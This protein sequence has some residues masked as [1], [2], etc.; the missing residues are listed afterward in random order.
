MKILYPKF[1][2]GEKIG[3]EYLYAQTGKLWSTATFDPDI[4]D[5]ILVDN[6][7]NNLDEGFLDDGHQS[8]LTIPTASSRFCYAYKI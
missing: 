7:I 5:D 4:H 6:E 1:L 8:D 2:T 3:I